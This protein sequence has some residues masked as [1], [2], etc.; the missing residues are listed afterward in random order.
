M[1][2]PLVAL[3]LASGLLAGSSG[4]VASPSVS[5]A[6]APSPTP[7]AGMPTPVVASDA[8]QAARAAR[9]LYERHEAAWAT[10]SAEAVMA[11]W[12]EDV[13]FTDVLGRW[14]DE[15]R[16]TVEQMVRSTMQFWPNVASGH[17]SYFHDTTGLVYSQDIWRS[18]PGS[19]GKALTAQ[20]PPH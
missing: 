19:A 3:M 11:F 12:S 10:K 7:S 15:P 20:A 5:T 17:L 2:R 14:R 18:R 9:S 13:R 6:Q 1:R 4:L 16:A 8:I